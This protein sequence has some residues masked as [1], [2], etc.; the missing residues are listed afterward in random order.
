MARIRNLLICVVPLF[1][2]AAIS[3]VFVEKIGFRETTKKG[4]LSKVFVRVSTGGS[5]VVTNGAAIKSSSFYQPQRNL[6]VLIG[7]A[8]CARIG[9]LQNSEAPFTC[10]VMGSG[11]LKCDF[12]S[13]CGIDTDDSLYV[14]TTLGNSVNS[15]KIK[16]SLNT[17]D[18]D[19]VEELTINDKV[20]N[21][22]QGRVFR[23][24]LDEFND[25][26][27]VEQRDT[28]PFSWKDR[29]N[30][31]ISDEDAIATKI[32]HW[33]EDELKSMTTDHSR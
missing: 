18:K 2:L 22:A 31:W 23:I 13:R 8:W 21:V 9:E 26:V 16:Y 15:L 32:R 1:V 30:R 33:L 19:I 27:D 25:V 3:I 11:L 14:R 24:R 12:V 10:V 7:M 29:S 6:G 5:N 17:I 4:S 20:F 28:E